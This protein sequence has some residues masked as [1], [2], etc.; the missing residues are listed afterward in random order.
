MEDNIKKL[1]D[2]LESE[3]EA[4]A[5]DYILKTGYLQLSDGVWIT[6]RGRLLEDWNDEDEPHG[7][8][9]RSPKED[10]WDIWVT[11]DSGDGPFPSPTVKDALHNYIY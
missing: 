8:D 4:A 9:A 10:T 3:G 11:T 2:I 6:T 1:E 7:E 5:H